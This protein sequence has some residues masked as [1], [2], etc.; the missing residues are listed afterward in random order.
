MSFDNSYTAVTGA[1][2]QASDYNT[3][4][5]GNFTAI[6]VGTTAGDM[7][8]YTSAMA[9]N[10]L[11]LVTGGL[12]Y[13]GASAPAWLAI[14]SAKKILTS[15]GSAP[16]W[17]TLVYARVGG[18]TTDWQ[19]SGSTSRTITSPMIQCGCT[20]AST[21]SATAVTFASAF[22]Y[23]PLIFLSIDTSTNL[24]VVSHTSVLS[25]G[26]SIVLKRTDGTTD[27]RDVNWMAIGE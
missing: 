9:K 6:W 24:F 5:K 27:T 4:T 15:S 17:G 14:G 21:S 18:S 3:S 26:F 20:N 22:S 8:Y 16:T 1:T 19:P 11:A 10:R 25:T 23:R 13:G 7:D 12:L 2:Y